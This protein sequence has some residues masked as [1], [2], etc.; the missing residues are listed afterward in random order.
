MEAKVAP[1][2][3]VNM[4]YDAKSVGINRDLNISVFDG[5]VVA[6]GGGTVIM[7]DHVEADNEKKSMEARGH[8]IVVTPEEVARRRN[9]PG[10]II[11]PAL[12][13][14]KVLYVRF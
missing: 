3:D 6:L 14:G 8:I 9:I 4:S 2:V 11:R 5:D 10:T 1:N 12:C 13:E 7:A